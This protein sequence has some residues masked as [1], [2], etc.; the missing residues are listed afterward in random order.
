G[1]EGHPVDVED[2]GLLLLLLTGGPPGAPVYCRLAVIAHGIWTVMA[3]S[4][5]LLATSLALACVRCHHAGCVMT[6]ASARRPAAARLGLVSLTQHRGG[7]K[8][9]SC[10]VGSPASFDDL[11]S[12]SPP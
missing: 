3:T 12:G 2:H 11:G 5:W 4:S 1:L 6:S 7:A 9:R 10:I 8:R